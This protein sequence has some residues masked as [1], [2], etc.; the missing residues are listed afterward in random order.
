MVLCILYTWGHLQPGMA[1]YN[2]TSSCNY[3]TV[4]ISCNYNTVIVFRIPKEE[5]KRKKEKKK[6][7]K[8][9]E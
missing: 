6:E 1:Q 7:K 5:R 2:F 9:R 4:T 3:I 8:K